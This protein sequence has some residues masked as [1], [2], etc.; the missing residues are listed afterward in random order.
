MCGIAGKWQSQRSV[1]NDELLAMQRV[2]HH[3]GPDDRGL[4]YDSLHNVG[5]IHTRL[6]IIDLSPLGH[7]PMA[8]D[9]KTIWL[10]YN[11]EVYN[12]I[13]LRRELERK[14]RSFRS[15]S[16]TEV[17]LQAYEEWHLDCLAR[18]NGMFAFAIWDQPRRQLVLVRDRVGVKPV[19]YYWDGSTF[20]FAS[21]LKALMALPDLSLQ[22]DNDSVRQYLKWGYVPSPGSIFQ[23]VSKVEPGQYVVL[24]TADTPSLSKRTYWDI[25]TQVHYPD[26]TT[27]P[28]PHEE[29]LELLESAFKYRMVSDVPVGLFLSG[30]IDSSLVSAVLSKRAHLP[31]TTFTIGFAEKQY[32]ESPWA[33]RIAQ[34][35]GT[36]HHEFICTPDDAKAAM[37]QLPKIY[38]EPFG[39]SSAIPTYLVAR[40]AR[41]RVT[42]ALSADGGDEVFGGYRHHI[43][44]LRMQ[45]WARIPGLMPALRHFSRIMSDSNRLRDVAASGLEA[46]GVSATYDRLRRTKNIFADTDALNTHFAWLSYWFDDEIAQLTGTA[47]ER[48]RKDFSNCRDLLDM[49]LKVDFKL[50]LPDDMLTKM[51]RACMAVSLENRDPLLDH[52]LVETACALPSRYKLHNNVSK[53]IL[54]EILAQ[55]LPADLINRKKMGFIAPIQDWC[56]NELAALYQEHLGRD[57]LVAAGL[58]DPDI[59]Q[60][61]LGEYMT[62][63]RIYAHKLWA[64]LM[65]Q[66]W[67]QQWMKR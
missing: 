42:V 36:D 4:Y 28:N 46:F 6:S 39:D 22:I 38:D 47:P 66:M 50:G 53:K 33:R 26:N 21:E 27:R 7:Q 29:V 44:T 9:S 65:L 51:D 49:M 1:T 54:R 17:I 67:W 24:A 31:L 63:G 15:Q 37:L 55:F 57:A 59:V 13:E 19:Y 58:L 23:N 60:Q 8:N 10:T 5:L 16:D 35:L 41:E 3:R 2:L 52:R 48:L 64:L 61:Y 45:R 12:F 32:D 56:R 18:F 11:G 62:R 40:F 34:H 43:R 20:A 30:G 14:G 25:A